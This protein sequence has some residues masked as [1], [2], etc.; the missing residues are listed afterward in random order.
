MA[1]K[2][3]FTILLFLTFQISTL[4]QPVV[5]LGQDTI[6]C[7]NSLLL[8][9]GNSG[10]T[11]LWSDGSTTQTINAD[12]TGTYWVMVTDLTGS[13][14]DT[15]EVELVSI[16]AKPI[17][18]DTSVCGFPEIL[19]STNSTA[20]FIIWS[21]D[22]AT[23]PSLGQ[24]IQIPYQVTGTKTLL[25]ESKNAGGLDSTGY[26]DPAAGPS[27]NY[28]ALPTG[29]GM[30]FDV[31]RNSNLESVTV[32]ASAGSEAS[33]SLTN[34]SGMVLQTKVASF[35]NQGANDVYLNFALTP[36]TN[37]RLILE[38]PVG[39]FYLISSTPYS[40]PV[41]QV[42]LK[43]GQPLSNQYPAFFNWKLSDLGCFSPIDTIEVTSLFQPS[44]DFGNDTI[45]C[46][47]NYVLDLTGSGGINFLW[48]DS[49]L[50]SSIS[51]DSTSLVW[52]EAE[53][54]GCVFRDTIMIEVLVAPST[55][56]FQ[57]TSICGAQEITL[58]SSPSFQSDISLW[59]DS[60]AGGKILSQDTFLT[61]LVRDTSIF[62]LERISLPALD[63]L[64]YSDIN[65][66][67]NGGYFA[68]TVDRGLSFDVLAQNTLVSVDVY[69]SPLNPGS[70]IFPKATLVIA[71]SAD[72]AI[73]S[74]EFSFPTNGKNIVFLNQELEV[75]N[76][77]KIILTNAS[78]KFYLTSTSDKPFI[79]E[80]IIVQG[81]IPISGQFNYFFNW[82]IARSVCSSGRIPLKVNVILPD[83][84]EDSIYSCEPLLLEGTSGSTSYEWSTGD[85]TAIIL[86]DTSQVYT[87]L[88]TDSMG[89]SVEYNTYFELPKQVDLG[90]DGNF[91]GN[92][93]F[94]GYGQDASILWSTGDT[95]PSIIVSTPD[96]Y[97]VQVD[98]PRG[99]SLSDTIDIST[100]SSNPV[101]EIGKDTSVCTSLIL[102]TSLPILTHL[103]STGDTSSVL[104][105]AASGLYSVIVTDSL[106]CF[107]VDTIGVAVTQIP[108]AGF[109]VDTSGLTASFFNS[110]GFGSYLWDFGDN[111]T[112]TQFNPVHSYSTAGIYTVRLI[113]MNECGS[114]T[115]EVIIQVKNPNIG[116]EHF[117]SS[118]FSLE[119]R[120]GPNRE[121]YLWINATESIPNLGVNIYDI[122]GR[123]VSTS[124]VFITSGEMTIPM[125]KPEFTP[126]LYLLT[127]ELTEQSTSTTFLIP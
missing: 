97:W 104:T 116:I 18:P 86:A 66:A 49:S 4:A 16:P 46:S 93:L 22:S 113:A 19:L 58:I 87:L 1:N 80:S 9:A 69:A 73:F 121:P 13:T 61:T 122:H 111:T 25:I 15:I 114:D 88:A 38:N 94:S 41:N 12:T 67:P 44:F 2:I 90:D 10:A 102:D 126:G 110:S 109:S 119:I 81:G 7:G 60:P 36:G 82:Q 72:V 8:D 108:A 30:R 85:T 83:L 37:Y 115:S 34:S 124:W 105:V 98:E 54:S 3:F 29:R 71:D 101:V 20:D 78:G 99:C 31:L 96:I 52:G 91:C 95:T 65:S 92:E 100:F 6:L 77:Y 117:F 5:D 43:R 120:Y 55:E 84:L 14:S 62:Y 59:Y 21:L 33:I 27:G 123:L 112:S 70:G 24:G 68:P 26:V 23:N 28:F 35:P 118:L 106:G 107:G 39:T 51:I 42:E 11:F 103:W 64:T 76:K 47:T 17:T 50:L 56:G 32:Y 127:I 125:N 75:G 74:Q 57:D 45:L 48:S 63:T 79:G 89:C 53:T 40:F